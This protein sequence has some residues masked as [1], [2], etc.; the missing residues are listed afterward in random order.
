MTAPAASIGGLGDDGV[1]GVS[2][3]SRRYGSSELAADGDAIGT[4]MS[5]ARERSP[6]RTAN[7]SDRFRSRV[8]GDAAHDADVPPNFGVLKAS[9]EGWTEDAEQS[10]DIWVDCPKTSGGETRVDV[11]ICDALYQSRRVSSWYHEQA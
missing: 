2:A 7:A 1:S 11:P 5:D 6:S 10:Q 3:L 8:E 9:W 4:R